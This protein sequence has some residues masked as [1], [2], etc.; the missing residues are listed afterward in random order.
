MDTPDQV[1]AAFYTAFSS[2]DIGGMR[3]LWHD[4]DAATC[5]HPGGEPLFGIE[6]VMTSWRDIFSGAAPPTIEYR[7]IQRH[8]SGEL[9]VHTVE[10][11]I[12]RAGGHSDVNRVIATNVYLHTA[13]G[14]RLLSHHASLPLVGQA[15]S[16][17]TDRPQVH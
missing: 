5:I 9:A 16:S 12:G 17:A 15:P 6:A 10:E 4:A 13:A 8:A 1:E 2:L 7:L 14:W 11:R 3:A